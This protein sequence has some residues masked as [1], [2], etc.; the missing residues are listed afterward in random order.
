MASSRPYKVG[1]DAPVKGV[2]LTATDEVEGKIE[3]PALLPPERMA[4]LL[5]AEL[6]RRHF[7]PDPATGEMERERNGV[8]M[9]VDPA[10]GGV[11]VS[12]EESEDRPPPPQ[13]PESPC[14]CRMAALLAAARA[15][16]QGRDG[17]QG[18][19]Q[20]RVTD[21]LAGQLPKIGCELEG[22]SYVVTAEALKE[23]AAQLGAVK[24]IDE[25]PKAGTVT[26]VV[27]V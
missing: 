1:I 13:V 11:T 3:L 27:A 2:T 12:A 14:G 22:I 20:E 16:G 17:Q 5:A 6:G 19:L 26:I 24:Q 7:S 21:R 10:T 15:E 4:A 25:D 9:T 8:K 18:R 23:K